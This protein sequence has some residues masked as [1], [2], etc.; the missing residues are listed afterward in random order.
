M[1]QTRID[2]IYLLYIDLQIITTKNLI[3]FTHNQL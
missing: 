3:D 2:I 1:E